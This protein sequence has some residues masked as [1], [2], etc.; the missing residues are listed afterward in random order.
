MQLHGV[1]HVTAVTADIGPNLAFYTRVLG[2]RLV[3]KSVNQDDVSAYHLFYAD[4]VGN[5]GTD[6][7]FFDWPQSRPQ[8]RGS[9]SISTTMFRVN[10]LPALEYWKARLDEHKVKRGEIETFGDRTLLRFEDAEGQRLALVDDGGSPYEAVPWDGADVPEEHAIHGF[11]GVAL[12]T[13]KLDSLAPILTGILGFS[14]VKRAENADHET[15]VVYGMDGGGP[16]KEIHVIEQPNAPIAR[17]GAG[18]VHHVA[19]RV[20]DDGEQHDWRQRLT[21][22]GLGVSPFID[23][24]Y[25]HS[26]YFRIS[27]GILFEIATDGPGFTADESLDKLGEGLALPP[28]L[29]GHRAE[30]EAGLRP[31]PVA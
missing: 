31:I 20:S 12:S 21:E 15:V 14:E 5:P 7:T 29:E 2:L 1:H 24:F 23:R 25:F 27:N 26:I 17:P 4:K 19:F 16:G 13:P 28:F 11:Y 30:I 8:R 9:D 3:K 10:G 18:S 6:M 22:A